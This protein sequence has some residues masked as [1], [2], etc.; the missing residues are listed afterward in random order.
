MLR[1]LVL[2]VVRGSIPRESIFFAS[3]I[4]HLSVEVVMMPP[5]WDRR[6]LSVSFGQRCGDGG[7]DGRL[8]RK[9]TP[10]SLGYLV[11]IEVDRVFAVVEREV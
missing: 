4:P 6:T 1:N 10:L 3:A 9:G 5:W 8:C 2:G 7:C 11:F